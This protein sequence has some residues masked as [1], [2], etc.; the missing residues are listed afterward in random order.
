[1]KLS[2][3]KQMTTHWVK[4]LCLAISLSCSGL[5]VSAEEIKT[6][7]LDAGSTI[8]FNLD[9]G[10]S[11]FVMAWDRDQAQVSYSDESRDL[12]DYDI[13]VEKTRSG[14]EITSD[15][16]KRANY[17][18]RLELVV[19]VPRQTNIKLDTVGGSLSIDGLEGTFSGR[20]AGGGIKILNARGQADLRTGGG[21]ILVRD[22]ILDGEIRTGGGEVLVENVE[23]D[24]KAWSGGG[25]VVYKNVRRSSGEMAAPGEL[26]VT[27]A[28]TGTVLI[29]SQGGSIN[30]PEALEGAKVRTAGGNVNVRN[31][32][33]F[34]YASTGGGDVSVETSEGPVEASTGA[35]RVEVTVAQD[36]QGE[37]DITI[38]TGLGD[39]YLTIP[40]NF[41]MSLE[42]ELGITRNS[43]RNYKIDSDMEVDIDKSESWSNHYGTPRKFVY[44]KADINGGLH[45]VKIRTTNGNVYIKEG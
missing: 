44:G 33:R 9:S 5:T 45:K 2:I 22:S 40:R 31:A 11:I 10:G 14:V 36:T 6:L 16:S 18:S 24:I 19:R 34:V 42:V 37:G 20:T 35:G 41:S 8:E 4:A 21:R 17:S 13:E 25:N 43:S 12:E 28:S 39:V 27:N 7:D 26:K 15:L 30:V 3:F 29:S 1:M 23:G 38:E 32:A